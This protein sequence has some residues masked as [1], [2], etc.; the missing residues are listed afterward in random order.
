MTAIVIAYTLLQQL[1]AASTAAMGQE[2]DEKIDTARM[3]GK[4]YDRV[5][6]ELMELNRKCR[7]QM[8]R[9]DGESRT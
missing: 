3:A 1:A 6:A 7:E 2:L 9:D 5:C 8:Q 4:V